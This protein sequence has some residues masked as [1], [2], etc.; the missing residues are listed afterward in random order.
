[1]SKWDN[2][3]TKAMYASRYPDYHQAEGPMP[4]SHFIVGALALQYGMEYAGHAPG[5]WRVAANATDGTVSCTL[6]GAQGWATSRKR[7]PVN[8]WLPRGRCPKTP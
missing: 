5:P 6:C 4:S 2:P 1:M 7:D 3:A 8:E